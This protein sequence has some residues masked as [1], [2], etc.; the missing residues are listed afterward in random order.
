MVPEALI[1]LRATETTIITPMPTRF[2]GLGGLG[3]L[4]GIGGGLNRS[5]ERDGTRCILVASSAKHL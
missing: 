4:G 3:G 2:A 5:C 1:A